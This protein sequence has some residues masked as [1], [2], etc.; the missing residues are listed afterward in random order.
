MGEPGANLLPDQTA[1]AETHAGVPPTGSPQIEGPRWALRRPRRSA[2]ITPNSRVTQGYAVYG[3]RAN[4]ACASSRF[5]KQVFLPVQL[6]SLLERQISTR[7]LKRSLDHRRVEACSPTRQVDR[8]LR[9]AREQSVIE[10]IVLVGDQGQHPRDSKRDGPVYQ[11]Q[12]AGML[13]GPA[14]YNSPPARS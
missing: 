14:R 2:R 3:F 8:L 11:M 10:R 9:K 12:E 6:A 13:V 7:C 1:V 5:R 4:D